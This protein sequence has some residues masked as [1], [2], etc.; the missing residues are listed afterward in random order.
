MPETET[1]QSVPEPLSLGAIACETGVVAIDGRGR[2]CGCNK[3]AARLAALDADAAPGRAIEV[4]P[5]LLQ[6]LIGD[7]LAARSGIAGRRMILSGRDGSAVEVSA[8]TTCCMAENG[9]CAGVIVVLSDI[10]A[11]AERRAGMQRLDR[12]ASLGTLSASMAHEIRNALVAVN[13]FVQDLAERNRDSELAELAVQELQR[14]DSILRQILK[15]AGPAKT[16]FC[17]VSVRRVLE[18]SLRLMAPE[19]QARRIELRRRFDAAQDMVQGDDYQ[20]EQAFLNILLNA[21]AAMERGGHLTVSTAAAEPEERADSA[22]EMPGACLRVEIADTGVGMSSE[23][24]ERVFEPFY[25]TK[26]QGTGLG[27]A[28]T[29][30]I[31]EEH[32]G[33]IR[34]ESELAKGTTFRV[35]LPLAS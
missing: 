14:I 12:L 20:L 11:V 16:A 31:V 3:E 29:R 28:I 10:A 35:T 9:T 19:L 15:S 27:L 33:T 32:G 34:A 21:V 1:S 17:R 22:A 8:T 23:N 24:L 18:H 30:R 5:P 7:T 4:L 6:E 13:T 25:T 26:P 2:I